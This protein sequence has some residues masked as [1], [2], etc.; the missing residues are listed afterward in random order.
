MKWITYVQHCQVTDMLKKISDG[1]RSE[2]QIILRD[3]RTTQCGET[4]HINAETKA[5]QN[6]NKTNINVYSWAQI[7]RDGGDKNIKKNSRISFKEIRRKTEEWWNKEKCSVE[8][9]K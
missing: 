6:Y 5:M 9:I 3:V 2:S 4:K 1:L 8:D 7:F